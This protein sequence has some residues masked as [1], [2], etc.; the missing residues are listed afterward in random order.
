LLARADKPSTTGKLS[1]VFRRASAMLNLLLRP[2]R[3]MAQALT[4][5]DSP[6]QTA[7][8]FALGMLVGLLPKGTLLAMAL[9]MLVFALRVNKTAAVLAIGVF[10]YLGWWLDD[11][12]HRLGAVVLLWA[13]ARDAFT[14]LF[15]MP[16]GPFIGFNNTVVMGQLLIGLYLFYPAYRGA[17]AASQR[18]Q[19]PV[20]RF[21]MRYKVI[22]WL[23]G[24]ELGAQWGLDG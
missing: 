15:D 4:A 7:W 23:R 6:R 11:F 12:A 16:L 21:L 20:A 14:W 8:G 13:P 3:L 22:R 1:L 2:L 24:A 19:P 10:S 17:Y 5:N 9:A 18:L